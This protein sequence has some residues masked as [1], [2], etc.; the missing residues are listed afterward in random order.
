MKIMKDVRRYA[1]ERG[2][3]NAQELGAG[4]EEK[5]REFLTTGAEVDSTTTQSQPPPR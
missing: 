1:A 3:N 5:S 2:I 4:L